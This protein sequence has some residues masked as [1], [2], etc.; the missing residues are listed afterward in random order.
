MLVP[1]VEPYEVY[2]EKKEYLDG[3]A[4]L[5]YVHTAKFDHPYKINQPKVGN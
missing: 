1:I 4:Y 3:L 5:G 2:N